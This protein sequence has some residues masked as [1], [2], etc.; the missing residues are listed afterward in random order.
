MTPKDQVPLFFALYKKHASASLKTIYCIIADGI[1]GNF[2]QYFRTILAWFFP[3]LYGPSLRQLFDMHD[4]QTLRVYPPISLYFPTRITTTMGSSPK[5]WHKFGCWLITF[6]V[7]LTLT[8][9][10]TAFLISKVDVIVRPTGPFLLGGLYAFLIIL[11]AWSALDMYWA[12]TLVGRQPS[13]S[14][15]KEATAKKTDVDPDTQQRAFKTCRVLL[16]LSAA[17]LLVPEAIGI[18]FV[19]HFDERGSPVEPF[20]IGYAFA[21]GVF[22]QALGLRVLVRDWRKGKDEDKETQNDNNAPNEE[23]KGSGGNEVEKLEFEGL[24]AITREELGGSEWDLL[25]RKAR[26]MV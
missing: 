21:I 1:S 16:S 3:L 4:S 20:F 13:G 26:E 8:V 7:S 2:T 19:A 12:A 6:F 11:S 9:L 15:S 14:V 23:K 18:F 10:L 25:E 24:P 5:Y 17:A 22:L